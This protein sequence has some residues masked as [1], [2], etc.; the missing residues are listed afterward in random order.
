VLQHG[1]VQ[2]QVGHDLFELAVFFLKLAHAPQLRW[3]NPGVLL[4]P[5]VKRG[6]ADAHLA[7]DPINAE[8]P[9]RSLQ[10][11]GHLFLGELAFPHSMNSL[12]LDGPIMPVHSVTERYGN[13]GQGQARKRSSTHAGAQ[14]FHWRWSWLETRVNVINT[15]Y[16]FGQ[17]DF[18]QSSRGRK[19][20]ENRRDQNNKRIK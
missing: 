9:L 13:L 5:L 1:F 11:V 15:K 16:I 2:A 4:A 7:T 10:R 6:T 20:A 19:A 14:L 18:I 12:A 17:P 3:T 8:T